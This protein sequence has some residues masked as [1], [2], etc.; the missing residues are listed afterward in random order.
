MKLILILILIGVVSCTTQKIEKGGKEM[1]RDLKTDIM[2]NQNILSKSEKLYG[3]SKFWQEVNYN[4]IYLDK[5][6]RE[7]WNNEYKK[8]LLEVQETKN[9]YEY[10]RLLKKFCALLKDGHTNIYYPKRINENITKNSFDGY[11]LF[12]KNIDGR[13]IITKAIS[14]KDEIPIGSEVIEVN[15]L[16]VWDYINKNVIPY[17]ASSTDYILIDF[18]ARDLLK[19]PIG[20]HFNVTI[21]LPSGE[22]K[23]L[24]LINSKNSLIDNDK[25]LPVLELKWLKNDIAYLALNSFI[26]SNIVDEFQKVLPELYKAKKLI[27]DLRE[28]GGGNSNYAVDI[29]KYFIKENEM[30]FSKQVTRLHMPVFKAWGKNV[31]KED[32][33]KDDWYKK[34]YFSYRDQYYYTFPIYKIK[35]KDDIKKIIVPTVVLIGH[36]TA[37]SSEDLLILASKEKHFTKIGEPTFGSTGQPFMFDLVGGAKSRVCAKKDTYPDGT[38]FVGYGIQPDIKVKKTFKDYLEKKDPVLEKAVKYLDNIK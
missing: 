35:I 20:T 33:D 8:L 29:I 5:V 1:K 28:N 16:K 31:K 36:D 21:K 11:K 27:I 38:E 12:F 6:N 37:S 18:G 14:E 25:S 4:F 22:F 10:Y 23:K 13:V 17:I 9:D 32:I 19:A 3:L 34:A 2:D 15:N 30:I 26:S 7:E 24:T